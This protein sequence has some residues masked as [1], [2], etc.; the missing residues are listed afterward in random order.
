MNIQ[1]EVKATGLELTPAIKGYVEEKVGQLEKLV[2]VTTGGV[3]AEVEVGKTTH[4]HHHGDVFRAE[5]NLYVNGSAYR[6]VTT[7]SD[8]YAAIDEMKDEVA[9]QIV[10]KK[11]KKQTLFRRSARKLKDF[12]RWGR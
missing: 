1:T 4:H 3:R 12:L 7:T 9:R 11:D 5:I 2:D 10:S 6:A 8:L